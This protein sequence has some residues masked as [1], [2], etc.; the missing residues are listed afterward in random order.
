MWRFLWLNFVCLLLVEHPVAAEAD[1]VGDN[2]VAAVDD[3]SFG[4]DSGAP[5]RRLPPSG[6]SSSS[7]SSSSSSGSGGGGSGS[8]G[9]GSGSSGSTNT[10]QQ[11]RQE[12]SAQSSAWVLSLSVVLGSA[13][14]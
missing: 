7:S 14:A 8:G 5:P 12:E 11:Q 6:G 13:V 3:G 4:S 2:T 9:G 10:R 1:V